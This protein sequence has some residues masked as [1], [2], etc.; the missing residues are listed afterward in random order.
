MALRGPE[1][2]VGIGAVDPY[3]DKR[4]EFIKVTREPIKYTG[5]ENLVEQK[6]PNDR[7]FF[8]SGLEKS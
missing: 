7:S 6:T 4:N 2:K 3:A 8:R 1:N 5:R